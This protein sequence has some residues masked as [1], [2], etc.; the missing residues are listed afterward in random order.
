MANN[1]VTVIPETHMG[2]GHTGLTALA[3]RHKIFVGDLSPGEFVL[4]L[5][6]AQTAFK[7]FASNNVVVHYKHERGLINIDV[8]KFIPRVFN[9]GKFSYDAALEEVLNRKLKQ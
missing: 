3:K 2:S 1:I 6:R 9:S 8:V 5:N 7:L 4:F